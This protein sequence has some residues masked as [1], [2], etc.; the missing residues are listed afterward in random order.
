[1]RRA[2]LGI[3]EGAQSEVLST[4]RFYK[5]SDLSMTYLG[6]TDMTGETKVRAE[7]MLFILE[8]GYTERKL[9]DGTECQILLD[10]GA[11]KSFM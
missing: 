10:V 3:Y 7:E 8:Q 2:Y 1:M 6:R 4:T 5:S 9:L 11:I